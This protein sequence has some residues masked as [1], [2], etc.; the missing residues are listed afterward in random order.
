MLR[1]GIAAGKSC[2]APPSPARCTCGH[3][4]RAA[5]KTTTKRRTSVGAGADGPVDPAPDR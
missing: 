2:A 3:P 1:D 5:D 4:E